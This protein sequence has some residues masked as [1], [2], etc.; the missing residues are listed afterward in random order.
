MRWAKDYQERHVFWLNGLAGTGESTIAQTFAEKVASDGT[1]GASFFCSRDYLDR[2]ELKNIFPTLSYQLACRYP[3]FRSEIIRTIK[4]DPSVACN[5]LISQLE[6]LIV[7]PLSSTKLSCVIIVDALDEC[8]DDQPASA[9]LSI[10]GRFVKKLPSVK[11]FITGRPEPRIRAGFRLPLLEPLTH[12]FLLHEVRLS[13]VDEDI[14]L[15][16]EV[17]LTEVAKRRSDFDLTDPWPCDEDLT[18]LTKK[19]SGLFIFASTLA[20]FIESEHHEPNERL[21]LIITTPDSTIHEGHA[22][23]D[24]LYTQVF[25]HAFSSVKGDAVFANLRRVLGAVV[26]AFNP[27][28]RK[29]IAEILNIKT[30]LITATLRHLHSVLL[31]PHED[32]KEIRIFHKSFPDFLQDPDRCS[33][34]R[35]FISSP[36]Y[37]ADMALGCLKLLKKLK[38]NPCDLPDFAMNRDTPNIP[39]LLEEKI[40]GA[41]RYACAY[42]AMHVRH[43]RTDDDNAGW[44]ITS[45]TEFLKKNGPP[46]IEVMS[47]ENR[48]EEVIHNINN[49]LDWLGMV[50]ESSCDQCGTLTYSQHRSTCSRLTWAVWQTTASDSR[51]I[52]SSLSSSLPSIPTIPPYPFHP[53]HRSSPPC[54]SQ[55]RRKYLISTGG[56]TNGDLLYE[57]SGLFLEASRV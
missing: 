47:L 10:L 45:T 14:R 24:P 31:V 19:S 33:D 39:D 29:E 1:L 28:S 37:H 27:L 12:V 41:T 26:L 40:G 46:W 7:D 49:L 22:G 42:W 56:L 53:S 35:F 8:V 25:L 52:S 38:R 50:C 3:A 57:P 5:S 11:F 13:N 21:Q 36:V 9:I 17:K 43:S 15:Y 6:G 18:T 23:I 51:C 54:P 20:R 32:S 30:S 16:L 4:R 44:L 2:K 55:K 48:L 34:P